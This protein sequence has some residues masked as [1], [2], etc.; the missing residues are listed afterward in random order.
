MQITAGDKNPYRIFF[1]KTDSSGHTRL[2]AEDV[3]DQFADHWEESAMDYNGSIA[4]ANELVTIELWDPS[5]LREKYKDALSWPLFTHERKR[6]R[7]RREYLDYLLSSRNDWFAFD[8]ISVRLPETSQIYLTLRR[9]V[10]PA[11]RSAITNS[12]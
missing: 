5:V 12:N 1:P 4:D 8:G 9:V 11:N 10:G 6:W 3:K 2:T 7:T